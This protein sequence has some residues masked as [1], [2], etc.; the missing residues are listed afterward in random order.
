MPG[1]TSLAFTDLLDNGRYRHS[2]ELEEILSS[3]G[4]SEN[5]P[6]I[7]SCGSGVTAAAITLA[8]DECG[9]GLQRLYDGS[10]TEWASNPDNPVA[11]GN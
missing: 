1:A 8:L 6:V 10:W 2:R 9:Y 3:H 5:T 7:T 11:V 4:V